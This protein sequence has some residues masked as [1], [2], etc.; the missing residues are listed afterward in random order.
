[1]TIKKL[2]IGIT[3]H[4]AQ[5]RVD[6]LKRI[7][8]HFPLLAE[9]T[10]VFVV[11]NTESLTEKNI[12]LDAIGGNPNIYVPQYI[13]HPY[14]LT[15]GHLDVF[16]QFFKEEEDITH[17]MYLEDDIEVK[18]N[19]ISYWL[20]GREDLLKVGLIP[21]FLRYEIADQKE[22]KLSTD[23]TSPVELS[24]VPA[25][26]ANESGNTYINLP[27]PYQGMYLLDR[28]LAREHLFGPSSSPD[29]GEWG[30][31]EKAAQG[32]TFAKI[33]SGCFSRNFIGFI[34]NQGC[35]DPNALIHHTPN[36]YANNP[37]SKFGK[38]PIKNLIF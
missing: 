6:F 37:L 25:F 22:E 16:R 34:Q 10:Q 32:L 20:Q 3:F 15:W 1:M 17:F 18:P 5:E 23:V 27:Q 31:R 19:N 12:I 9:N 24:K 29:F 35:I 26:I 7:A 2:L 33:P 8:A 28:E 36:N 13:G 4:F 30:I 38:I 11:T 21:S 14:L